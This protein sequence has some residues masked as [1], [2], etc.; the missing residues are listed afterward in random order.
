LKATGGVN[1]AWSGPGFTATT[2]DASIAN[3]VTAN[4][5]VYTVTVTNAKGCVATATTEVK[6]NTNP[7]PVAKANS[8]ICFN[9]TVN[10]DVTGA[11]GTYSWIGSNGFTS[12]VQNPTNKPTIAGTVTYTVTVTGVGG[13]TGTAMV[14]VIV[15]PLPN[16][17]ATSN[18]PVCVGAPLNL[19]ATGGKSY[20]WSGPNG[21]AS[22]QAE[23]T[24]TATT[25]HAGVYTVTVTSSDNCTQTATTSVVVNAVPTVTVANVTVCAGN[26]VNLVANTNATKYAWTSSTGFTSSIQNPTI[27]KATASNAGTYTVKV[28]DANG[29]TAVASA[30]VVVNAL[31]T[32]TATGAEVCAGNAIKLKAVGGGDYAWT[33]G[34]GF[35]STLAEPTIANATANDAGV[36]TVTITNG[37]QCTATATANVIVN[38]LPTTTATGAEVCVGKPINLTATAGFTTYSWTKVGGT[39]TATTQSPVVNASAVTGDAGTY[40]VL[41]TN[42]NGCTAIATAAVIVNE[43]PTPTATNNGPVCVGTTINLKATGGVSYAWSGING[44][45]ATTADASIANAVTANAGVYTVTVTNAKGCVATATTEVKVNTNPNPV[46][47][48]NTTIC[49]K[50]TVNLGITGAIAGNTYSWIGSNGFTSTEQSPSNIPTLAGTVTYTV[51]VTGV[52]G[53]T[54]TATTSV[55]VKPNPT[56]TLSSTT[57][58]AGATGTITAS[59]ADTYAWSGPGTFTTTSANLSV[60]K[61]G[62]YSVIGTTNGCTAMA[63]STVVVNAV[64]TVT[65]ANVTVCAGNDVNLVA[66]TNATKFSWTSSTGYTS[67]TQSPTIANATTTSTGTYTITVENANGCTAIAT[68]LVTVNPLPTA[69]ASANSPVCLGSPITLTG[70]GTGTNFAWVG[71]NN[72]ASTE[73]NPSVNPLPTREGTYTYMV[74]VK[75]GNQCSA[76]ATVS[77]IVNALPIAVATGAEV[78][79]GKEIKLSVSPTFTTY[80]WTKVGGTF[81]A[82][83]QSPVVNASAVTGDAGTYQV[84]VTDVNGCTAIAT[85]TVIVNELPTPTASNNGPVCVGTTIN[86]KA[87]GGVSYA[88]SGPGFTATTADASI[89]NAVNA[90]AGVYTVTVTNAKGCVATATTEVKVNTNPNPT[91]TPIAPICLGSDIVLNVSGGAGNKFTWTG[92]GFTSTEQNPTV[93][94]KPTTAGTNTYFVTVEGVGG[95]TGTATTSVTVKANPTLVVSSASIC[96]GTTGKLVASGADVYAWSNVD[97]GFTTT[98]AELSV[99]KSGVYTVSGVIAGCVATATTTVEVKALPTITVPTIEIC[100][101]TTGKLVATGGVSYAWSGP[102]TFTTTSAELSVTKAGIYTVIGTNAGGCTASATTEVKVNTNPNPTI[103]AIAPICL[104]GE[105]VLNVSGGAGNKFTWTGSGFTSTEQNPTVSPKPTTAGTYTYFVTVEGVGG[106]TGTATTSVIANALPTAVATGAEVCV[107][108]EIKLSV[109]PSFTTYAWTKVGGTFTATT[110]SPVVNASAVTGDAGTY[111]VLVTNA[112]GCTAIATATVIVNELPTPTASNNGPVCVGTTINLKATGGV[113]YAWSG[114]GFTAT[115]AEASIANAVTAN[116]G[117]YTVTVTNAKGCTAIATTEVKINTNPNP[118]ATSNTAVCLGGD[119]KLSV[120]ETTGATYTWSGD[121]F[122]S[123]VREPVISSTKAGTFT[124]TVTVAGNGGCTGT[125]TTSVIVNALPTAVATGA[126]V[127]AGTQIRVDVNP[128][129]ASYAWTGAN[130]FTATT[131]NP[132]V[133]ANAATINAGTYQV[134]VRD[135]NGCTAIATASV[136]VN[137]LPTATVTSPTSVC[138]SSNVTL[139]ATGGGTY[140]W[141]A[142]GGFT[143]T[144]A[145]LEITNASATNTGTFSVLVTSDKGCTAMATTSVTLNDKPTPTITPIAPICLGSDIVLNVSGG[146]GNKFTWTGS[147]F[148]STEQNPTVSPKPTTSG[149][150]TYFVTVEGV[151]GCT[152]TATTSITV[153]ANPTISVPSISICAGTTGKLVASGADIYAWSNVDGGF[154]T[155]SAELSVTKGGVYTVSGVIG[156]CVATATTTVEVKALPTIT[157]S[158]ATICAGTAGKLVATGGVSYAWSGPE[159]F[160]TTSAELSVTKAGTYTV[161]GTD[162]G[163]C[164]AMATTTLTVNTNPNPVIDQVPAVCLGNGYKLNVTGGSGNTYAWTGA[165]FSSTEQSPSVTAPTT[166]GV[167]TYAVL[168]SGTGGCT[169]TATTSVTVKAVPTVTVPSTSICAGT[170]GTLKASTADSYVWSGDNNFSATTQEVSVTKAGTYTVTITTNGCTASATTTVE[171]K[172]VP[173]ITVSSATICAGTVGKLKVTETADSYVWSGDNNF[174]ATTQEVSVSKAGTYTVTITTNGCTASATTSVVENTNPNPVI[175]QVLPVCLGNGYKLNVTVGSGNTY[176]WIGAGFSSTEQSPSVTAPTT[177]GVYTYAVLVSGTGG[178][179]GTA[180]TSVTVKAVPTITVSSASICAV[181]VGT[182]KVTE[183][184]DSYVWSGDNN[185]SA[186]TQEVSVSKAGTYTVTI[187]TNG[188]TA[189]ATTTVE[190]KAVP[191]ITVSSATICAG[192]VGTLKVTETDDSYVW[193]GDNNFSATT[194]EVSVSKAGTY[195]VTISKNGCTASATTSV[196]ENTNPNPVIEQVLPVCLG[197]GYKLNVTGGSGNTYAWTGAG[198]SS[199]E[200]NPSVT[201]PTTAGVY[202]YSV[203]VSGTGGCTGTAT[204]SVTVKAIPTITVSSASICAGTTDTL[205]A[206]GADS[207]AWT[208]PKG[209]F[210]TTTAKLVIS[211]AGTYTVIG[212]T[213]GCS[214]TATTTVTPKAAA[215]IKAISNEVCTG[216]TT[217]LTA[218]G[219]VTYAWSAPNGFTATGAN[220]TVSVQQVYTV[221]GTTEG[222]CIGTATAT[223]TI[224]D[225][226]TVKITGDTV[227]CSGGKVTLTANGTGTFAWSGT[228]SFSATTASVDVIAGTYQVTVTNAG[229]SAVGTIKVVGDNLSI[230]AGGAIVCEGGTT[231]LTG[232]ATATTGIKSYAW[233]GPSG[234][235]ST[236]KSPS[237]TKPTESGTYT[238]TVI[239]NAGCTATATTTI[240]VTP[241][242]LST[243]TVTFCNGGK[244]TLTATGGTGATYLWTGGATTSSIE[245]ATAGTY[246]VTITDV[247]GCISKGKFTVTE[248]A[249]PLAVISGATA[250]CTSASTELSVNKEVTNGETYSWSGPSGFTATTQ[251]VNVSTAGDYTVLVKT[252]GG[253]EATTKVT[254]TPGF[255]PTAVC[256]PVCEGQD[257]ILNVTGGLTYSWSSPNGFTSSSQNPQ[258]LNVKLTD[259]GV[260]SVTVTGNGCT[261]TVVATLIVYPKPTGITATAQVSTCDQDTP[262]NDGKV[263]LAGTFTGLKYDIVEG[264][265]YTGTKK[266]ADAIDVPTDGIIKSGIANPS[267]NAGTKYTVRV[268][269]ANN[270]YTDYTVT[271]QQVVCSC[272]EAKCIPYGIIKTKSA[273]K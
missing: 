271:M 125:A 96:A 105:I 46:A 207:Y 230:Q 209:A 226:P 206:S 6:V 152:G 174:S 18:S 15:N 259:K 60:T 91:I 143:S 172:A 51:T 71:S 155:T 269:N 246:D 135:V 178:C 231:A 253:C 13:C 2:A 193:S 194:Q 68:A 140:L 34:K 268:F 126:E 67:S 196:V 115:T 79:V 122:T 10:L 103:T 177:A 131:K 247:T 166:A 57:I 111:Q 82:T 241:A 3:A 171:V 47:T 163:G 252:E 26:D 23:P 146:A 72:F 9:E 217:T 22:T 272:G 222:G 62:T 195:T 99:T 161:I 250:L 38:A 184:A 31:P 88:W 191:T 39:F 142:P 113:N 260:Y 220:P 65:V 128:S 120:T 50:E 101:G 121:N 77:V 258:L 257:L 223:L 35:T 117:V 214:V 112:N 73:Q 232:D 147:G 108:K 129:F 136:T 266:Y 134:L 176:A 159:T 5:G 42:A 199:T 208:G 90:N 148:T 28:E 187:T 116:A 36:Y 54:G 203:L 188:C 52:G 243:A 78:C 201:A 74:T 137:A 124:Y 81:T 80:A 30:T 157:V 197:N 211:E 255:T 29:C 25:T 14:A 227:T 145:T 153:K 154:T 123:T 64:P 237:V 144:S 228:N 244:A 198:F 251:K 40:Q 267:T 189:V 160:T 175:D 236:E 19:K 190:V 229:C 182:L 242:S 192:T 265:T 173:T 55:I 85:A 118:I 138:A 224:K 87:T 12:T 180:T 16:A 75:N 183:T 234:F 273:K 17:T 164:T 76:T 83:T 248:T 254:V 165:G 89:A 186:T 48:S 212:T 37:T 106:C 97:G 151:G 104:G 45:T 233:S 150:Y 58:C 219:G 20:A 213:N 98:S 204:T 63:T 8:P 169:G 59:G 114:P 156:G 270:C 92:S 43:L 170:T 24:V 49:L 7:A 93:S 240:T 70:N 61:E 221:I 256:G 149:T 41:V 141:T 132:V 162:A 32:A 179:T 218:T 225:N 4:A 239:S 27:A 139:T 238:L 21:Y 245:V 130:N 69:S 94:P 127:C 200:Q 133:T 264:S 202:T 168:V 205:R 110:Q 53:C 11:T 185:F 1:Y 167:Y 158:S 100:A 84:L 210:T 66:N 216:G 249:K 95:C 261:A 86:L 119:I 109:S 215:D 235:T 33:N 263:I 102:E 56:V 44:F 262:K 107:G 181:T